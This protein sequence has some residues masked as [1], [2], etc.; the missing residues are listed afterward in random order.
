MNISLVGAFFA[1]LGIAIVAFIWFSPTFRLTRWT[2]QAPRWDYATANAHFLEARRT[3]VS[4]LRHPQGHTGQVLADAAFEVAVACTDRINE[5][6]G[7]EHGAAHHERLRRTLLRVFQR[8]ADYWVSTDY[9]IES[10]GRDQEPALYAG[11][12]K[13]PGATRSVF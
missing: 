12:Q 4:Q 8:E 13:I 5:L 9:G 3:V 11:Q 6:N 2:K 1:T 7:K 10:L